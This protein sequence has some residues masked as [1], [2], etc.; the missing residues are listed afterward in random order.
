LIIR[1]TAPDL[2]NT[3]LLLQFLDVKESKEKI[4]KEKEFQSVACRRI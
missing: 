4:K 1:K 3:Q 2:I